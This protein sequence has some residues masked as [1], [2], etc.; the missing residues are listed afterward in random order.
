MQWKIDV[1]GAKATDEM[2]FEGLNSS[3][4][5]IDSVVVWFHKLHSDVVAAV[6]LF[7]FSGGLVVCDIE[8]GCVAICS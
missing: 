5:R 2:I 1:G 8:C 6:E 7:Y 4:G 3:F